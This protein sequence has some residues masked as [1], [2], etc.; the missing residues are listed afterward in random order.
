MK[1]EEKAALEV[2][3]LAVFLASDDSR[4]INGQAISICSGQVLY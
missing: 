2:A 3:N 4:G 1:L